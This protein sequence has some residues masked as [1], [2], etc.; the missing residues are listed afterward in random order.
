MAQ[1]RNQTITGE[2][3]LDGNTYINCTFAGAR[4]TYDGGVPPDFDNCRFAEAD[5]SFRGA[6]ANTVAFMR[7]LAPASTNMRQVVRGLIPELND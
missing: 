3:A 6:A 2:T 5:F 1:F 4:L 7:L